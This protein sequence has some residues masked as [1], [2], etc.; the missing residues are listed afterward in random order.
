LPGNRDAA[1]KVTLKKQAAWV[2][3]YR[4]TNLY[5][6]FG[7]NYINELG[8]TD[9]GASLSGNNDLIILNNPIK[10]N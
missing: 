8:D 7:E 10:P 4:I 2:A 3:L 6:Y 1:T 5:Y 9:Q